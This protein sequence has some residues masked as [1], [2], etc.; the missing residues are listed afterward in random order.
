[1]AILHPGS[2]SY[3][4]TKA[5]PSLSSSPRL[6]GSSE[7]SLNRVGIVRLVGRQMRKHSYF[8]STE[9]RFTGSLMLNPQ[10]IVI[11]LGALTLEKRN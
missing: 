10:S 6:T 4:M 7:D 8:Q 11:P 1:M 3:A 5:Q 9:N 2:I